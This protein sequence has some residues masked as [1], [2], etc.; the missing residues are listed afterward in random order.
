MTAKRGV[1]GGKDGIS[2]PRTHKGAGSSGHAGKGDRRFRACFD[3]GAD[4]C[5]VGRGGYIDLRGTS[6]KRLEGK[7]KEKGRKKPVQVYI[8]GSIDQYHVR[9]GAGGLGCGVLGSV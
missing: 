6:L 8:H 4:V 3:F 5:A 1:V 2:T 9:D 7:K